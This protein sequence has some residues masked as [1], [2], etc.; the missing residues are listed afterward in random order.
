MDLILKFYTDAGIDF[1]METNVDVKMKT[2]ADVKNINVDLSKIIS[3]DE[4]KKLVN[5]FSGCDL[6]KTSINTVFSDGNPDSKIMLIGEAP[7]E[8]EDLK[9]IPFCGRSG[10]LLDKMLGS[11]SLDRNKVYIT[12]TIFW[13]PPG[14]R[15]PSKEEIE[16]CRPFLENHIRIINPKIIII[17]GGVAA[18]LLLET[19]IAISKLRGKFYEYKNQYMDNAI[20]ATVIFHP[21]YL[22]RQPMQKVLAWEDLK[23]IK[24]FLDD[25]NI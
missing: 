10:H 12:N 14:N 21:A 16:I 23:L 5:N 2:D 1:I 7:G 19:N 18:S 17:V 8:Q 11:I 15:K 9:G 3:I 24:N 25:Q 13:R 6:K 22:L 4:L 20:T